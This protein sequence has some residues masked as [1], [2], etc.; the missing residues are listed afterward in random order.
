VHK[1]EQNKKC[2]AFLRFG[3][4]EMVKSALNKNMSTI[5]GRKIKVTKSNEN[6]TIFIGNIRKNWTTTDVELKVRRIVN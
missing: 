6:S 5:R 4:K 1:N 3:D 2:Y